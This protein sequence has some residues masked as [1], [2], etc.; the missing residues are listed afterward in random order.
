MCIAR[1]SALTVL[2][3]LLRLNVRGPLAAGPLRVP[4]I[5][6]QL[7]S[8]GRRPHVLDVPLAVFPVYCLG[9]SLDHLPLN[10]P[11]THRQLYF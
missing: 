6:G 11:L 3:K 2:L 9:M 8:P 5:G 1:P 4:L 7:P 10:H